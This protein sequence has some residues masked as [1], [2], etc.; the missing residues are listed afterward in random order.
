MTRLALPLV[1]LA[2]AAFLRLY[3]LDSLPPGLFFDEAANGVDVLHILQGS[4]PIFFEANQGREPLFIYL[5]AVSVYFLGANAIALRSV[6]VCLGLFTVAATFVLARKWFGYRVGLLSMAGIAIAFWHVDLSRVGLRAISTPFFLALALFFFWKTLHGGRWWHGA[7]AGLLIGVNFYSYTSA[8]VA[9]LLFLVIVLVEV[10]A[11]RQQALRRWR[12]VAMAVVVS[13]IVF[14]P[15]GAYFAAHPDLF[16][17][18]IQNASIAGD[19]GAAPTMLVQDSLPRVAGMFF[20]A[21]DPNWRHNLSARPVF[22]PFAGAFFVLGLLTALAG[23]L[24]WREWWLPAVGALLPAASRNAEP[25]EAFELTLPSAGSELPHSMS[26]GQAFEAVASV[27]QGE[28]TAVG[29]WPANGEAVFRDAADS[30]AFMPFAW[31]LLWFIIMLVPGLVSNESPHFLRLTAVAPSVFILAALGY[32]A[33]WEWLYSHFGHLARVSFALVLVAL[34]AC[35]G[36]STFRDYFSQWASSPAVYRAFD[37][38]V[39][40]AAGYISALDQS[41]TDHPAMFY[42]PARY[43]PALHF[44][45]HRQYE[46]QRMM[47][48]NDS[49]LPLPGDAL[50]PLYYVSTPDPW[51]GY[52]P[53]LVTRTFA[54]LPV[55]QRSLGPDGK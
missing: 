14:A 35:E 48:D 51:A 13:A 42:A 6:S 25:A 7:L 24:R 45:A 22:S 55:Q 36:F 43:E 50:R 10:A 17:E 18:R 38:Q 44:L 11:N 47:D 4:R 53:G 29:A 15:L 8:R 30:P 20:L 40:E 33:A 2:V 32:C 5:Q 16:F 34:L 54:N 3:Q 23:L 9:A 19:S 46:S 26:A 31:L 28:A 49:L 41:A 1:V 12:G 39:S 37:T 27:S 21:G 52:W